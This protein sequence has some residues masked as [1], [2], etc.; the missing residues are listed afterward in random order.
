M[1]P[2]KDSGL[3]CAESGA[4]KASLTGADPLALEHDPAL[5][6]RPKFAQGFPKDPA[7]DLLVEA[8]A[9]GNYVY[10]R[11]EAPRLAERAE[12]RRVREA[13]GELARRIELDPLFKLLLALACLLL[14][15]LVVW[16]YAGR[17]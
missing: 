1:K 12:S 6:A 7:L 2:G 17:P 4:S 11:R 15:F 13:A 16:A 8:F 5:D 10:V 3:P 9:R 14:A